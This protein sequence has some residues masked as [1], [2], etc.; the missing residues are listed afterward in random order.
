MAGLDDG[1]SSIQVGPT[2]KIPRI[3][4]PLTSMRCC[5]GDS[6][7]FAFKAEGEDL[8]YI[9][10]KNGR[11]ISSRGTTDFLVNG[12]QLTIS[13]VYGED[14]GVYRCKVSH[15]SKGLRAGTENFFVIVQAQ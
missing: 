2:L 9:W 6:V 3:L 13:K 7:T 1:T 15:F 8:S 4:Q 12:P 14:E 10:D 11:V 5:D